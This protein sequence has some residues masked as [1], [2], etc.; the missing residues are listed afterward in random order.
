MVA[1]GAQSLGDQVGI[2][3][4]TQIGGHALADHAE[5]FGHVRPAI[6]KV[7]G[8]RNQHVIARR[9]GIGDRRFPGAMAIA[10][11]DKDLARVHA[12]D[13]PQ[14]GEAMLNRRRQSLVFQVDGLPPHGV[15]HTLGDMGR[16]GRA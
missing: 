9:Q 15:Q 13:R 11:V 5:A 2:G 14:G 12:K 8:F 3:G 7:T 4:A 10:G 16:A 1:V 6:G